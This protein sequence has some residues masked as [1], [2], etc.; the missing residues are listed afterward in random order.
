MAEEHVREVCLLRD[1]TNPDH[2]RRLRDAMGR[3]EAA[4]ERYVQMLTAS[5]APITS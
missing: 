3:Q 4:R 2:Q 1:P 5:D